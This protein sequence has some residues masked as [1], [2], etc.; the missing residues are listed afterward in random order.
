MSTAVTTSPPEE[1]RGGKTAPDAPKSSGFT[2][3][4]PGEGYA[5]RLGLF[6]VIL[7]YVTFAARQWFFNWVFIPKFFESLGWASLRNFTEGHK[8]FMQVTGTVLVAAVGLGLG[9][10]YLY[11]RRD[12]SE[13]LIRTDTEL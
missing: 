5:T 12:S 11:L 8:D 6:V 4:K 3:Y 7:A 13:F 9:Y 10:Y 2:V 1:S